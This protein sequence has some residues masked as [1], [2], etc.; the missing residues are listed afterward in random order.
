MKL[1]FSVGHTH[2]MVTDDNKLRKLI[3]RADAEMYEAKRE[4]KKIVSD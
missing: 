2:G 3:R 4:G 1:G